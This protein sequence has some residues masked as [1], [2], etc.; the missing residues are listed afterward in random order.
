MLEGGEQ[1]RF[2]GLRTAEQ[3]AIEFECGSQREY[4]MWTKGVALLLAIVDGR[5]R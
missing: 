1:Q 2:F 5:K 4:K 3:R